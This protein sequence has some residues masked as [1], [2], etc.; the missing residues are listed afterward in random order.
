[1]MKGLWQLPELQ[2]VSPELRML[3]HQRRHFLG[4]RLLHACMRLVGEVINQEL[5]DV[6]QQAA[7]KRLL[8]WLTRGVGDERGNVRGADAVIDELASCVLPP[9]LAGQD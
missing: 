2:Q 1:M 8:A 5:A 3:T 6:M 7:R 9:T 4:R